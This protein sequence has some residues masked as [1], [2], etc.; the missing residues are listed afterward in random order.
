M[1][2][3]FVSITPTLHLLEQKVPKPE[4]A[5]GSIPALEEPT[6]HIIDFDRSGSTYNFLGQLCRDIVE[7]Y[8]KARVGDTISLGW[9]SSP[10]DFHFVIKGFRVTGDLK[11]AEVFAK[12]VMQC[13]TTRGTTCFSEIL[14]ET[15]QVVADLS[16]FSKK[17]S[18]TF[19]TDGYPVV[20]NYTREIADIRKAIESVKADLTSVLVV[21]YGN[22]YNRQLLSE[23][24]E[25]FGGTL[26]H[27]HDLPQ[28]NMQMVEFMGAAKDLQPRIEVALEN[29]DPLHGLV[30]SVQERNVV[31]LEPQQGRVVFTPYKAKEN[32][33]YTLSTT[34]PTDG[35][36]V[37][38]SDN[39]VTSGGRAEAIVKAVY[40]AALLMSQ[41]CK[42]NTALDLLAKT[43]DIAAIDAL[44][45]AYTN[46]EYGRAED[47]LAASISGPSKRFAKGRKLNY[48][49][50]PAAFCMLDLIDLLKSDPTSRIWPRHKAFEYNAIGA[51]REELEGTLKFT[52]AGTDLQVPLEGLVWNQTKLNLSMRVQIP[53]TV[54][55]PEDSA[56]RLGLAV[57]YP[58]FVWRAYTLIKDGFLNMDNLPVTISQDV[59]NKLQV[60]GVIP[61]T[62][63]WSALQDQPVILNLSAIPVMNRAIGDGKDK[64]AVKLC[65]QT[66]REIQLEAIQKVINDRLSDINEIVPKQR[67]VLS[68]EAEAY[69]ESKG[70]TKNGFNPKEGSTIKTGDFYMA[71][72]F[73]IKVKGFSSHPKV[74]E[75]LSKTAAKKALTPREELINEGIKVVAS[76]GDT[77]PA[78]EKLKLEAKLAEIKTELFSIRR[79]MRET[80]FS[81]ILGNHWFDE[82]TSREESKLDVDGNSFT[83]S[84]REV[85]VNL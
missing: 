51:S 72:E 59:F 2:T 20:P 31:V 80:M 84:L 64:S 27:A 67:T 34:R 44:N 16:A 35:S 56:V 60:E 54:A 28:F 11:D 19:L 78:I 49:P 40:A 14:G 5:S 70:V 48:L 81:I 32:F 71:K 39:E 65:R 38:L 22:Y 43:G 74:A 53:G 41:R 6:N 10:G 15:K 33:L 18:L 45:N 75:V 63:Q 25:W 52:H 68:P 82:L 23:M 77:N 1:T 30:F 57:N 8:S 66:Y 61:N 37:E 3:R 62:E 7:L 4:E 13:A 17:F 83:I 47:V 58:T 29:T 50:D 21:G 79:S 9:F 42:V 26:I 85:Q 69:L 73:E 55:L 76:L 24:A 36:E 46:D 12:I